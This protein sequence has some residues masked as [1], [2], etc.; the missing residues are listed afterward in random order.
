MVHR[1]RHLATRCS[2]LAP[3]TLSRRPPA[4][5]TSPVVTWGL[6]I[7]YVGWEST[8]SY[9]WARG[10]PT[11][12]RRNHC[13]GH[14]IITQRGGKEAH[15][16]DMEVDTWLVG[17]LT[18]CLSRWRAAVMRR[19]GERSMR[20]FNDPQRGTKTA[21]AG[22]VPPKAP[23]R[24]RERRLNSIHFLFESSPAPLPKKAILD[25]PL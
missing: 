9:P 2:T 5:G 19:G 13:V 11:S 22:V 6:T 1:R 17:G 20:G 15:M 12:Q 18:W 10:T 25:R 16:G 4:S 14:G 24:P 3:T 23:T 21:D 7:G 8:E